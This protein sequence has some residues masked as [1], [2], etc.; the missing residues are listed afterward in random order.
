MQRDDAHL[1][2][3]L[4]AARSAVGFVEGMTWDAFLQ[5]E[6][7]QSAVMRPLEVI[8]EAARRVTQDTQD[9]HPEI[10]WNQMIGMRNRLVHEYVRVNLRTVWETV[11]DDLPSL[12]ARIEPLVPPESEIRP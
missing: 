11:Q 2:D 4:L 8:G 9:A 6:L 5:S 3:I 1:L 12:I 7:H 10:P